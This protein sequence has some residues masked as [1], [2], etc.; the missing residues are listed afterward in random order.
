ML[1]E[2]TKKKETSFSLQIYASLFFPAP[3]KAMIR[4]GL[5]WSPEVALAAN[6]LLICNPLLACWLA[7]DMKL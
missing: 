2:K 7:G 1:F 4:A 6:H 5:G 3:L